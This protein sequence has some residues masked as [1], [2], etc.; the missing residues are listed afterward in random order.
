[1]AKVKCRFWGENRPDEFF[2]DVGCVLQ[3]SWCKG[4]KCSD[5]QEVE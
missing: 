2:L 5:Y 4:K 1:M 3:Y